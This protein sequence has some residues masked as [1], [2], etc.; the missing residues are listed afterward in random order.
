MN[1]EQALNLLDQA[2]AKLAAGRE[3]HVQL[4]QAVAVLRTMIGNKRTKGINVTPE[5]IQVKPGEQA[6]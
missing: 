1:E 5:G 3:A 2:V 4:L 6:E